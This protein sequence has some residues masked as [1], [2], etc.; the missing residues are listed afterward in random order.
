MGEVVKAGFDNRAILVNPR[1]LIYLCVKGT[2]I[3]TKSF[4]SLYLN[5]ISESIGHPVPDN[6]RRLTPKEGTSSTSAGTSPCHIEFPFDLRDPSIKPEGHILQAL[7]AISPGTANIAISPRQGYI[8]ITVE[9]LPLV[10]LPLTI[11]GLPITIGESKGS[12]GWGKGPMFPISTMGNFK[13]RICQDFVEAPDDGV[14]VRFAREIRKGTRLLLR[15]DALDWKK[16]LVT[17]SY[18]H[19]QST[20]AR[21]P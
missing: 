4:F 9:L 20:T 13:I 19:E 8:N 18:G 17:V 10:K 15:G 11:A 5:R 3:E 1:I 14:Y 16:A 6:T 12:L 2:S 21:P 7:L